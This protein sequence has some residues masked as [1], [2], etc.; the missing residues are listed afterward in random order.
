MLKG[1]YDWARSYFFRRENVI[2]ETCVSG[3]TKVAE[4]YLTLCRESALAHRTN[5]LGR[6]TTRPSG[7]EVIEL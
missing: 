5:S 4:D 2:K 1:F 7:I 3:P 6:F